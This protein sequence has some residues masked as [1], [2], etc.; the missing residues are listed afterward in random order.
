MTFAGDPNAVDARLAAA[1][2]EDLAAALLAWQQEL[3]AHVVYQRPLD[4]GYTRA[5]VFS[6]IV[7]E[8]EGGVRKCVLKAVPAGER[9]RREGDAHAAALASGPAEFVAAHLVEQPYP[10]RFSAAGGVLMFQAIAGGDMSTFRPLA[11]I[12]DNAELPTI[13]AQIARSLLEDWDPDASV[14]RMKARDC[15]IAPG[16]ATRPAER[17][18]GAMGGDR[19]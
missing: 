11:N 17:R 1:L 4:G 19:R 2:D 13:A 9:G 8:V 7:D 3:G 15:V 5:R 16:G 10:Q 6:V 14:E 12:Y 18:T